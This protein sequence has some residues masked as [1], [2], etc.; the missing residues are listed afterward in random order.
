MAANEF[1]DSSGAPATSSQGSSSAMR[2]EFDAIEAAFNK[3]PALAGNAGKLIA[4]NDGGTGLVPKTAAQARSLLSLVVGTDVQAYDAELAALA[5]L[6]SAADRLPYFTGSATAALAVFT[7]FAR[8][9]LDDADAGTM[10]STLGLGSSAVKNTG[11]SGDAVPLLN[12]FNT[13][14]KSQGVSQVSLTDAVNIATDA[15]LGNVF[16]VTLAGPRTL[17]NPTNLIAGFTYIWNINQDATGGRT[18]AFGSL[19]KFPGGTLP[20]LSTGANAKDTLSA[21]YDGTILRCN[22]SRG[23]A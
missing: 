15:S 7:A 2:A 20:T 18:L 17:D 16:T 23:Y 10:R 21:V 4:V 5:G 6:V 3:L 22:F 14:S 12:A 9:L 19:F 11:A 13:W 1:Y 8:T